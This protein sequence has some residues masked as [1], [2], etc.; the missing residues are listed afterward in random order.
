MVEHSGTSSLIVHSPPILTASLMASKSEPILT[1][2]YL[3]TPTPT[4]CHHRITPFLTRLDSLLL[5]AIVQPRRRT[6][7]LH[8]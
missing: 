4:F 6:G 2:S 1:S 7:S 8:Q 3:S 5:P